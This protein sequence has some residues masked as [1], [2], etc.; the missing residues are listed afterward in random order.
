MFGMKSLL[1]PLA[2][3][4]VLAALGF[5]FALATSRSV[6]APAAAG[7]RIVGSSTLRFMNA[8]I[9]DNNP[10]TPDVFD[11]GDAAYGSFITRYVSAAGGVRPY[12][13]SGSS[14]LNALLA[15]GSTLHLGGGGCLMGTVVAPTVLNGFAVVVTDSTGTII[16]S[17]TGSFVLNMIA[18]GNGTFRFAMTQLNN[19][20]LG[21]SYISK[22][23]CVGG[24]APIVYSVLPGTLTVNGAQVG[25]AAGL[26]AIGLSMA[27]DGTVFGRPLVTG[28]VS[29]TAH[30]VDALKR[31]ARNR[32]NS[33]IDQ[34]MTFNIEENSIIA[35]DSLI[36]NCT[37]KG[38]QGKANKDSLSFSG[39]INLSGTSNFALNGTDFA[40]KIG[41]ASV[42]GRFN[43]KGQVVNQKGG[44]VVFADG[45]FP[46]P[47][48]Q[49][50]CAQWP[51]QGQRAE[52][53]PRQAAG[54]RYA[55]GPRHEAPGHVDAAV[56]LCHRQ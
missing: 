24:N 45:S 49:P 52:G 37:A 53:Q 23:E 7:S 47:Q 21:Q 8:I 50:E 41:G 20:I 5:T 26:E 32:A 44:P 27:S 31:V 29:F 3:G 13:F 48:G 28:Q 35:T 2:C 18:A 6:D 43:E 14:S 42:E 17:A 16:Q 10:P 4:L 33:A 11:L 22:V 1:R 55:A 15:P 51:V 25:V 30:A 54:R 56:R 46:P 19:G 38:D 36:V 12:R 34:V 40:L 9:A 39:Y